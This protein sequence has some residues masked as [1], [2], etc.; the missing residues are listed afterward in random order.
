MVNIQSS[1]GS[2]GIGNEGAN[3]QAGWGVGALDSCRLNG[4]DF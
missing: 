2:Y 1:H 3:E 4:G